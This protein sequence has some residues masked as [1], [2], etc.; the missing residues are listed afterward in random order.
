MSA[1][2]RHAKRRLGDLKVKFEYVDDLISAYNIVLT[3]LHLA[4]VA[5]FEVFDVL[6]AQ[7]ETLCNCRRELAAEIDRW[8]S[9]K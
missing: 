5:V 1:R 6:A 4:G 8:E 3:D 2:H 7:V 9:P